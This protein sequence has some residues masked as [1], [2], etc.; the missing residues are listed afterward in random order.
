MFA[1][2]NT[3]HCAH[4]SLTPLEDPSKGRIKCQVSE[5]IPVCELFDE[6]DLNILAEEAERGGI[7]PEIGFIETCDLD[8]VNSNGNSG[9]GNN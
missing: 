5:K 1:L 3:N 2:S 4:V 8:C 6:W 7:D 9:H